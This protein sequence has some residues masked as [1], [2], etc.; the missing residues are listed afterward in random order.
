MKIIHQNIIGKV[1]KELEE[2]EKEDKKK[3]IDML[4]DFKKKEKAIEQK[5]YKD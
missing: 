3:K 5:R 2:K 1:K 4:E